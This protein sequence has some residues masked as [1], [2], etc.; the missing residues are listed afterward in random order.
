MTQ[1]VSGPAAALTWQEGQGHEGAAE[2]GWECVCCVKEQV[3]GAD[4]LSVV[5]VPRFQVTKK[6]AR[7]N[8]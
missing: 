4:P 1:E 6:R 8:C 3:K 7:F 5:S 2:V